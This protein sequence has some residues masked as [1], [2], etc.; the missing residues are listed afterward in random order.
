MSSD[1]DIPRREK[2]YTQLTKRETAQLMKHV[3]VEQGYLKRIKELEVAV[4]IQKDLL[5]EAIEHLEDYVGFMKEG[6][7]TDPVVDRFIEKA[8]VLR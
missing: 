5:T 1:C 2:G 4:K 3:E 8:K 6:R 7:I